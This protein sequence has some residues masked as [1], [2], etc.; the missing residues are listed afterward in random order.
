MEKRA[1]RNSH[2]PAG[3]K[4]LDELLISPGYFLTFAGHYLS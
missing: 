3:R 2:L 1:M 4:Q